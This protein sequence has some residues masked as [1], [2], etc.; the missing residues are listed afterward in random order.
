MRYDKQLSFKVE[1]SG[2]NY[3]LENVGQHLGNLDL[4]KKDLA[5]AGGG[6]SI[7]EVL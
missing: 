4:G 2:W 6:R 1:F 5:L 7:E 3:R